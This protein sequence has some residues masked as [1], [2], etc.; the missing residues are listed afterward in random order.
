LDAN[1][2]F[3]NASRTGKSKLRQNIFGG[4]LGG[5]VWKNHTFFFFDY[6]GFR[7]ISAGQPTRSTLPTLEMG[8]GD[9]SSLRNAQGQLITIYDPLTAGPN[10]PRTPFAGNVIPQNRMDPAALK[11]WS[12]VPTARRSAGDP[13]TALGNN[14]YLIPAPNNEVQ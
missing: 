2:W 6:Q 8:H 12:F 9:F 14:T 1:S 10:D 11:I 7:Q 4:A 3:S 13:L 5:P